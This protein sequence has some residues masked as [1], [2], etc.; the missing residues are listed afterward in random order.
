MVDYLFI[1]VLGY[2][3]GRNMDQIVEKFKG[4]HVTKI[5]EPGTKLTTVVTKKAVLVPKKP[6]NV[7]KEAPSCDVCHGEKDIFLGKQKIKCP[8]CYGWEAQAK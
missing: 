1:L 6:K 2:L 7:P 3:L 4:G 8:S 5:Q